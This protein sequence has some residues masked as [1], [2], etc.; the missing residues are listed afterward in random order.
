MDHQR[1]N[2][3]CPLREMEYVEGFDA[4]QERSLKSRKRAGQTL[5]EAEKWRRVF[6]ILFPHVLD[7]DIPSPCKFNWHKNEIS[8]LSF[9]LTTIS[10]RLQ[11]NVTA[12]CLPTP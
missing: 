8:W 10:L 12:G 2:E 6:K 5:S 1:T 3:P 4:A 9:M 7:D 11:P